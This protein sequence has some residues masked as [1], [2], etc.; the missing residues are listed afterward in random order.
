M[1]KIVDLRDKQL[2]TL[3]PSSV[4]NDVEELLLSNNSLATLPGNMFQRKFALWKLDLSFNCLTDLSFLQCFGG[5]GY[6]DIRNNLLFFDELLQIQHIYIA[7]LRLESNEF[8]KIANANPLT[9]PAILERVWVLDGQF[10]SDFIRKRAKEFKETLAFSETVLACRRVKTTISQNSSI[11]KA[12]MAF[13]GGES[14]RVRSDGDFTSSQGLSLNSCH[15][16]PQVVRLRHLCTLSQPVLPNGSFLEYFALALGILALEWM[17]VPLDVIVRV[18]APGYWACNSDTFSGLEQFER[19]MLLLRV[20]ETIAPETAIEDGLWQALGAGRYIQTGEAPM[21]GAT[22]RLLICAFLERS[23]EVCDNLD[24]ACYIKLRQDAH[25]TGTDVDLTEI[26]REIIAPIPSEVQQLPRKG[27]IVKIRHPVTGEWVQMTC[28]S[29]KDG[30][31]YTRGTRTIVQI[32]LNSLFWDKRGTW[33]EAGSRVVPPAQRVRA[34]SQINGAFITISKTQEEAE[35]PVPVEPPKP[36]FG[37]IQEPVATSPMAILMTNKKKLLDTKFI[38]RTIKPVETFRGIGDPVAPRHV[39]VPRVKPIR[40]ANRLVQD[41]VNVAP[42]AYI[43]GGRQLRRFN[44]RVENALTHK[45]Q[46]VW[47]NEDEV[48]PEDVARLIDLYQKHIASKMTIIPGI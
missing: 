41:V 2:T 42:G 39:A 32:P 47:I 45:S 1:T 12:A 7:H 44:V 23:E 27:D 25:F 48:S 28:Q 33:R 8:S 10:I 13:L 15:A 46:Y 30:R 5:L 3:E 34:R 17:N 40:R 38:D 22:P 21:I 4:P 36:Q 14:F 35:Q 9:I 18:V 24:R 29:V 31:V 37:T 11:S 43:G 19:L 26:H 20:C 6:L 16:Q